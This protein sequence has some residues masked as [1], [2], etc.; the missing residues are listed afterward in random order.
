MSSYSQNR[1]DQVDVARAL[2]RSAL[3]TTSLERAIPPWHYVLPVAPAAAPANWN[4]ADPLADGVSAGS[5]SQFQNGWGNWPA[6]V[7][8]S[9]A[10]VASQPLRFRLH[11]ATKV[12]IIGGIFG[13]TWPSIVFTLPGPGLGFW[14]L[15]QV[16]IMFPSASGTGIFTG[17]VD[18]SGNVWI[19]SQPVTPP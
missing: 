8:G 18:T 5:A 19:T 3:R 7:D 17:F 6:F 16:T 2:R 1:V 12:E 10:T 9:G 13:G 4:P 14:P 11:P 15:N